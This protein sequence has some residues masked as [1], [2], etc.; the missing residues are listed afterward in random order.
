MLKETQAMK[1]DIGL[2]S[3]RIPLIQ[4]IKIS[5]S[6]FNKSE[7]SSTFFELLDMLGLG[8]ARIEERVVH[9]VESSE[10]GDRSFNFEFRWRSRDE[11]DSYLPL[12]QHLESKGIIAVIVAAGKGLPNRNL[13]Y[14]QLWTLKPNVSV[15]SATLKQLGNELMFKYV[16][17]G[18]TDL[19]VLQ[20]NTLPVGESNI[21]YFIEVKAIFD[22]E[23]ALRES[24]LQLIGGNAYNSFHSPPV[25]LTNLNGMH[26]VLFLTLA[27]NPLVSLKFRLNVLKM[28]TFGCA[29]Q[30]VEK[31]TATMSS[32]TL[33][34][35]SKPTPPSSPPKEKD[36]GDG[37]FDFSDRFAS[38]SLNEV[39][40]DVDESKVN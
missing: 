32:V 24:V 37:E 35:G 18:R 27:S 10:V 26:Y 8:R 33:H 9:F 5:P 16:L 34:L 31:H 38:V 4:E 22:K 23:S 3:R 28:K 1:M 25:L 12:Q 36:T 6:E 13:F 21:R 15:S 39:V 7:H 40:Q 29:L 11:E 19:V 30:F 2:L 14:K 17:C 20:D